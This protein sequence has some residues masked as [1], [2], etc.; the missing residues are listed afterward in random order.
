MFIHTICRCLPGDGDNN[1]IQKPDETSTKVGENT[2]SKQGKA[3]TV[4][5][6]QGENGEK[7]PSSRYRGVRER[8]WGKF[9]SEIRDP[10]KQGARVWLGTF[11]TAED[12]ALAYDRAAF[13]IRGS[14]AVLN[15]P[16]HEAN[17]KV[18]SAQI[19]TDLALGHMES[20][21]SSRKRGREETDT[22]ETM[23]KLLFPSTLN[24]PQHA[25]RMFE[26]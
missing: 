18:G 1:I 5:K 10:S 22:V 24:V 4:Q 13:R 6:N 21:G 20:T 23:E 2:N 15:F 8:P 14:R 19:Q 25:I 16:L 17:Y 3:P 7:R 11:K 9:A 12:A 26:Q